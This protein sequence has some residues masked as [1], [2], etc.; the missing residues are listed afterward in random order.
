MPQATPSMASVSMHRAISTECRILRRPGRE[1]Y[2]R[3][4]R[5][6]PPS[7]MRHCVDLTSAPRPRHRQV[8]ELLIGSARM[9]RSLRPSLRR[10][11]PLAPRRARL[12]LRFTPISAAVTVHLSHIAHT[13][14]E[15]ACARHQRRLDESCRDDLDHLTY[16]PRPSVAIIR[17]SLGEGEHHVSAGGICPAL[18]QFHRRMASCVLAE[19]LP[20]SASAVLRSAPLHF[21]GDCGG[22]GTAWPSC[23]ASVRRDARQDVPAARARL[24]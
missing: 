4:A 16:E 22:D 14:P 20:A 7:R 18:R 24:R 5:R 3:N 19:S 17:L 6:A 21:R 9:R 13:L 11:D 12:S 1:S 23:A 2:S 10:N 8:S 15:L